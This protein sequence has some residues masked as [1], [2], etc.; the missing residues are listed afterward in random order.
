MKKS[1]TTKLPT[2]AGLMIRLMVVAY[3]IYIIYSLRDVGTRYSGGELAFYIVVL[4]V[5][6]IFALG[7]TIFSVRDLIKGRYV[8]GA[9]DTESIEK[10]PESAENE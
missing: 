2:K 7:L 10:V 3:L 5:F 8:G 6:A 9:M 1:E 4:A